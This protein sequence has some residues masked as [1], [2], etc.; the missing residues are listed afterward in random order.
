MPCDCR[1]PSTCYACWLARRPDE[2]E[3]ADEPE[4]AEVEDLPY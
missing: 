3:A 4:P 1:D 2:D